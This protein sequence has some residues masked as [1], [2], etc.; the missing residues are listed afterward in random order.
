MVR[1]STTTQ[2]KRV[3]FNVDEHYCLE[4]DNPEKIFNEVFFGMFSKMPFAL[5]YTKVVHDKGYREEMR[6]GSPSIE[7]YDNGLVGYQNFSFYGSE[8]EVLL[9]FANKSKLSD[10][11]FGNC[12]WGQYT[13]VIIFRNPKCN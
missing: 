2:G 3:T 4:N 12:C 5:G 9:E 10:D 11:A 13:D 7:H 8:E 6:F 1:T